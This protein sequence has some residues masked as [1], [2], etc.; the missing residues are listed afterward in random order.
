MFSST[1]RP[2]TPLCFVHFIFL[3]LCFYSFYRMENNDAQY[4][5]I[6]RCMYLHRERNP[7]HKRFYIYIH[8]ILWGHIFSFETIHSRLIEFMWRRL[9]RRNRINP[10]EAMLPSNVTKSFSTLRSNDFHVLYESL[11]ATRPPTQNDGNHRDSYRIGT[12]YL[13]QLWLH[14]YF[15]HTHTARIQRHVFLYKVEYINN[16]AQWY[17]R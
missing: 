15:H 5:Y 9:A 3:I 1:F 4:K 11:L 6:Y 2:T 16:L 17:Q 14:M 7:F 13:M 12:S 8:T 10:L